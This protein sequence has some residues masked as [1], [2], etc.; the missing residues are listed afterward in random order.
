MTLV[1]LKLPERR[2]GPDR[3]KD[4]MPIPEGLRSAY[5]IDRRKNDRRTK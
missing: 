1:P 4:L 5:R 3:R 2:Y